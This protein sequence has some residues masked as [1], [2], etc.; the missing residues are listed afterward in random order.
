MKSLICF[1]TLFLSTFSLGNDDWIIPFRVC[2]TVDSVQTWK[3]L[4]TP[5]VYKERNRLYKGLEGYQGCVAVLALGYGTERLITG[6]KDKKLR[7][8][9][10]WI[11]VG[12]ELYVVQKNFSKGLNFGFTKRW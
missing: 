3:I 2:Y 4:D 11:A 5:D 12:V 6:I 8:F 10:G 1:L 9:V 7:N